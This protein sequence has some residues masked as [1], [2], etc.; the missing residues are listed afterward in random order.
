M[1][2]KFIERCYLGTFLLGFLSVAFFV[3]IDPESKPLGQYSGIA[4]RIELICLSILFLLS[5]IHLV[6]VYMK[7]YDETFLSAIKTHPLNALFSLIFVIIS[8]V[9]FMYFI[10]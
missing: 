10:F 1:N 4:V 6:S 3:F 7:L 9:L 8:I 2:K 5:A